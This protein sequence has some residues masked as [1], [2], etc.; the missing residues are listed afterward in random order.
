MEPEYDWN[1]ILYGALP[2]SIAMIFAFYSN[3][4]KGWKWFYLVLAVIAAAGITYFMDK[5]KNNIFT[6][7]FIVVAT[8][9]LMYALKTLEFF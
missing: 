8:A 9:L 2:A 4:G 1:A 3:I 7:A 6:S 5:K